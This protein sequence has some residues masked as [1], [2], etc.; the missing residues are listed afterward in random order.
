MKI[1]CKVGIYD[2]NGNH[3]LLIHLREYSDYNKEKLYPTK[4]GITM[5][6]KNWSI[7]VKCIESINADIKFM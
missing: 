3:E 7:L 2:N 4:Q 6:L 5:T 1:M